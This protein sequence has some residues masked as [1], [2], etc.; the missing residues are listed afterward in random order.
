MLVIG[1]ERFGTNPF[2]GNIASIAVPLLLPFSLPQI[3]SSAL[4]DATLARLGT[5]R[6]ISHSA[7]ESLERAV[8]MN[9][10]RIESLSL[11][12]CR[13][14][15]PLPLEQDVREAQAADEELDVGAEAR[16]ERS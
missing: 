2:V 13:E 14:L 12:A 16:W 10:Q 11:S 1:S 7:L 4:E 8:R 6:T 5:G 15:Q 9:P 3:F